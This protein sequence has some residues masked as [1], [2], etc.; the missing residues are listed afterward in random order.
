MK[1]CREDEPSLPPHLAASVV[2]G[3][4]VR[5]IEPGIWEPCDAGEADN[6][7]YDTL[8]RLYDFVARLDIYHRVFW[9]ISTGEYRAFADDAWAACGDS[10]LLDAGCGSMLFT[11]RA[12]RA[13]RR[14]AVIGAD[15]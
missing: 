14:G 6:A 1:S 10:L 4:S 7:Q 3:D 8:G 2:S 5:E 12:H 11:A 15:V 13:N 9:G